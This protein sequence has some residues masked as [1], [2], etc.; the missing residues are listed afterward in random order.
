MDQGLTRRSLLRYGGAGAAALTL[1]GTSSARA[2]AKPRFN[3][4]PFRLGIASG[5]P[6]P[7]GV[8]LWTRLATDPLGEDPLPPRR[9]KLRWELASDDGFRRVVRKGKVDSYPEL[10]HSVHVELDGL[11]PER[12][13]FYRFIVGDEVSPTGRTKTAPARLSSPAQLRFALASCQHFESGL[14][15]SYKH[16]AQED[17]DLVVHVGDFIYEGGTNPNGVRQHAGAEIVTLE[18]YRRRHAQYRSDPDLQAAHARFPFIVTFDDHETENN[19]A[20]L[21]SQVDTEPDQDPAVFAQRRAAAYQAY[22][23]NQPLRRSAL[24]R[25]PDMQLYRWL[26]FGDLAEINVL[27][28]RQYRSDQ[29]C[30]DGTKPPCPA[31]LDPTRT[32]LGDRQEADVL[33]RLGTSRA[34]WNVLANQVPFTVIDYLPGEEVTQY[35]D[36]WP[37]YMPARERFLQGV[38]D[39]NVR[40]PVVLTGDVHANWATDVPRDWRDLA[41]PV[42][43]SEF[44]GT[45]ISSGGDGSPDLS[46]NAR[47]VLAENPQV[48]FNNSQRGYVRHTVTPGEWRAD[49]RVVDFVTRP[50]APISTKASF[51]IEEGTPGLEPA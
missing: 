39:R 17:L 42:V 13:Y 15:T 51:V 41:S 30:G 46:E 16:M 28:T 9:L 44:I 50:G 34:R 20:G 26:A 37:G 23:E 2:L 33:T 8:V 6:T 48:K 25:G 18:D 47:K 32:I 29:A 38:L 49:Y 4:Y 21:I 11:L 14:Y 40:N 1:T 45:S 19:Y 22:Y 35:M 12:E 36:A 43:A 7:R 24:P 27:D 5:D 3:G 10:A 31:Q